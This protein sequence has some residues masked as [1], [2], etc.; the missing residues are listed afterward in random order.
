MASIAEAGPSTTSPPAKT[1]GTFVARVLGSAITRP[2]GPDVMGDIEAA[3]TPWP[4]AT[5]TVSAARLLVR[6]SSN[7]GEKRPASS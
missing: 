5:I 6:E 7:C 1:P 3:S 4:I 2:P